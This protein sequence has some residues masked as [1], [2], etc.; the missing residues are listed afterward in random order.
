LDGLEQFLVII[1]LLL[2]FL[3]FG[4]GRLGSL[5]PWLGLGM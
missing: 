4:A 1:R 3:A 2:P 5:A